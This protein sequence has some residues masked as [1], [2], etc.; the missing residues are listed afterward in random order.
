MT[1]RNCSIRK[2]ITTGASWRADWDI[3][4]TTSGTGRLNRIRVCRCWTNGSRRTRPAKR[5]TASSR[6]SSR[7][8]GPTRRSSS[9][10]L[11]R[12]SVSSIGLRASIQSDLVCWMRLNCSRS[13]NSISC[14]EDINLNLNFYDGFNS[15]FCIQLCVPIKP[16][17]NPSDRRLYEREICIRHCQESN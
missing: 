6:P 7:W 15:I 10:T 14:T 16:K 9:T 2:R 4:T 3:R 13:R 12:L 8:T 17:R 1:Y 5:P 11:C